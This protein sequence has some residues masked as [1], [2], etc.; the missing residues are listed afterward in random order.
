MVEQHAHLPGLLLLPPPRHGPRHARAVP[1]PSHGSIARPSSARSTT[2]PRSIRA[3][4]RYRSSFRAD[5]RID[6]SRRPSASSTTR[7]RC[8]RSAE[9]WPWSTPSRAIPSASTPST[10]RRAARRTTLFARA[11]REHPLWRHE[12][13]PLA[14]VFPLRR[15]PGDPARSEDVV[16]PLPDAARLRARGR[17]AQHDRAR[18]AGAHAPPRPREPGLHAEAH[19]RARAPHRDHRARAPRRRSRPARGRPRRRAHAIRC[20]SSSSRR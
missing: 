11:R 14:S 12:G 3:A 4:R 5:G 10:T 13:L 18:S 17:A 20:R 1:R 16:E 9:A 7:R 19:P 15:L 8:A 2:A 6:C